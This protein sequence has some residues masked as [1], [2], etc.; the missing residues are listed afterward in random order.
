[1]TGPQAALLIEDPDRATAAGNRLDRW[2]AN[3]AKL[4]KQPDH[5]ELRDQF[6]LMLRSEAPGHPILDLFRPESLGF[7][8]ALGALP[9]DS[10]TRVG[11]IE[12]MLDPITPVINRIAEKVF[13]YQ[14]VYESDLK[15]PLDFLVNLGRSGR[16]SPLLHHVAIAT[17][18]SSGPH[19]LD[20]LGLLLVQARTI[21][22][23]LAFTATFVLMMPLLIGAVFAGAVVARKLV[24][25]D[26]SRDL[27]AAERRQPSNR[28]TLAGIVADLKG[29]KEF[30][31]RLARLS[32]RG[33]STIGVVGRRGIGKSRVLQELYQST[34]SGETGFA[35]RVWMATPSRYDEEDFIE[36][37][38]EQFAGSVEQAVAKHLGADALPIRQ[39]SQVMTR[40]GLAMYGAACVALVFTLHVVYARLQRT[41]VMLA[42]LPI[43]LVVVASACSLLGHLARLQPIDLTPWLERDRSRGPYTMLLYRRTHEALSFL[44]NR[45]AVNLL[46]STSPMP[47]APVLIGLIAGYMAYL[48]I[49][50]IFGLVGLDVLLKDVPVVIQQMPQSVVGIW[51]GYRVFRAMNR[52]RQADRGSSLMALVAEY[53]SYSTA[54]VHRLEQGALA[55][56]VGKPK[57]LVCVDELDKII[58][59]DELRAFLRRMKAIFEVPGIFYYLSLSEDALASLYLGPA[60]GKDEVD[61]S[62][63]HVVQIPQLPWE[64]A[65]E[66]ARVYLKRRKAAK[67]SEVTIQTLV[68]A[69]FGVPRDIL[70]RCDELLATKDVRAVAPKEFLATLREEQIEVATR[71]F[72]WPRAGPEP[73]RPDDATSTRQL[74]RLIRSREWSMEPED[75]AQLRSLSIIWVFFAASAACDLS[76]QARTDFHKALYRFGYEIPLLSS[77]EILM[78]IESLEG[79]HLG[80]VLPEAGAESPESNGR[81]SPAARRSRTRGAD[82]SPA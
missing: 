79:T 35:I 52:T 49:G 42:W 63:D 75:L 16:D 8:K 51:A 9:A 12:L 46:G 30:L 22:D 19:S 29:R 4:L 56:A 11:L 38:L 67:L 55:V 45:K 54:V 47:V 65:V 44:R 58:E 27:L 77:L 17:Y 26:H 10:K 13:P 59:L 37:T 33:W 20:P 34:E 72:H 69:S 70:R 41:E 53:R 80:V 36:S 14:K 39:L 25:R 18:R 71:T 6:V 15:E 50:E 31:D 5:K 64:D 1:M 60:R 24:E 81:G 32:G 82:H 43:S 74:G 68:V 7:L 62:L 21:A 28:G 48:V 73:R 78:T 61:S 66:V 57:V 3:Y 2:A 23:G 76:V 40:A